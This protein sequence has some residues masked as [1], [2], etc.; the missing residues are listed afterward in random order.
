V[1]DEVEAS[2]R[3]G[4]PIFWSEYNAT[5]FNDPNITDAAFMGPWLAD[6]LRQCD[7]LA[8]MMSY[9]TF[10][11][12]FEEQGVVKRP[13]YGGFGLIA[14]GGI[15]KPAFNAFKMLHALGT[16]R[17]D[18]DSEHA[19]VT[20]RPDG[21]LVI[22]LWNYADPGPGGTPTTTS[23][24]LQHVAARSARLWRLDADHGDA[25]GEYVRMGSPTYPTRAQLAQLIK[26]SEL[27]PAKAVAIRNNG[28]SV[29]LP[30]HGLAII[31]VPPDA[32][33]ERQTAQ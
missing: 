13:L 24:R 29:T 30:P 11:D 22:A 5:Y 23:L 8:A 28:L 33:L 3:P 10:S 14:A 1:H 32:G 21:S 2:P 19:L 18:A 20:R 26:A 15:P 4:V 16:E 7:G 27:P 6:T 12:V 31:E 17:I 9:W 25:G